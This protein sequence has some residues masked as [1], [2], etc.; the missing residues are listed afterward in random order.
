MKAGLSWMRA[1]LCCGGV[2]AVECAG[3]D[4]TVL[5]GGEREASYVDF[6]FDCVECADTGIFFKVKCFVV[7]IFICSA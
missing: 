5:V 1:A 2:G 7:Y 3:D 4:R 6:E